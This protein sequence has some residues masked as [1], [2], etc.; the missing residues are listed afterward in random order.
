MNRDGRRLTQ[1]TAW[2][3]QKFNSANAQSPILIGSLGGMFE[4]EPGIRIFLEGSFRR[5]LV[6]GFS[7]ENTQAGQPAQTGKLYFFEEYDT[8]RDIWTVQFNVRAEEPSGANFRNVQEAE[9][10]L[11]GLCIKVGIIIRF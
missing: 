7:G 3:Y 10:D 5:A 9:I 4:V 2:T 1:N 8:E 6:S 11:S